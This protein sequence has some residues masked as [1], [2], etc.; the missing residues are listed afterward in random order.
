[1]LSTPGKVRR[2]ELIIIVEMT[3]DAC[4]RN[5]CRCPGHYGGYLTRWAVSALS[6]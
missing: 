6:Q 3:G 4:Q 2:I 1:M 5:A